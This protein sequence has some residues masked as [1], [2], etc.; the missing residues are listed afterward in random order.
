MNSKSSD[1]QGG[2]RDEAAGAESL[3]AQLRRAREARNLTL[4][5][6]S[7]QTR[8]T[9][10]HLEAIE[11]DDYKHLPGGIFNRSFVKAFARAVG[12]DEDAAVRAYLKIARERGETF[13]E[14]P[15]TR[16]A[17][18]LYTDDVPSRSPLITA[19][20]SL[21]IL[22]IISLAAYAGLH[23]YR[24]ST[25]R[26][27]QPAPTPGAANARTA[28]TP[29]AATNGAN[30]NQPATASNAA[31]PAGANEGLQVSVKA[32]GE[33]VWIRTAVDDQP[34][35]SWNG[36]LK[37]DETREISAA[38]SLKLEYAKIKAPALE[39]TINGR[40]AVVPADA[41]PGKILVEMIISKDDY[42]RLLQHP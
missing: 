8:I 33:E 10:R 16:Q 37:P 35:S 31:A 26:A 32:K 2:E 24:R 27:A 14:A 3:G 20:L 21:V 1:Q 39:V 19:I 34:S 9:R 23:Y 22:A 12:Y 25:E 15:T 4:R 41:K 42:E 40:P 17:S 6:I 36:T 29:N 13:D 5:E 30:A 28:P 18:R 7:D 38:Q 11:A